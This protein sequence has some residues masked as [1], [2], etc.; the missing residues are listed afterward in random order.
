VFSFFLTLPGNSGNF[1][2]DNPTNLKITNLGDF[3][4]QLVPQ[5]FIIAG[6]IL[7]GAIIYS[8]FNMALSGGDPKKLESAKGCLINAFIGFIVIICSYWIIQILEYVLKVKI[9]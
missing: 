1:T 6:L 7:F 9:F 3:I 4:S 2:V 8:G 5:L